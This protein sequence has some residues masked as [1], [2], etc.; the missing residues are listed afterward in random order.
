MPAGRSAPPRPLRAPP[1]AYIP[2]ARPPA[3]RPRVPARRK[4]I[5]DS[6]SARAGRIDTRPPAGL[7]PT[8]P[9]DMRRATYLG[10]HPILWSTGIA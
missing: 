7:P 10:S 9:L 3:S 6:D 4:D 5:R 1:P 8:R 2:A